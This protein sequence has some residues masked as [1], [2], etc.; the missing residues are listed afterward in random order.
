MSTEIDEWIDEWIGAEVER[1]FAGETPLRDPRE[2]AARG[3]RAQR[4]RRA[5]GSALGFAAVAVVAAL[6]VGGLHPGTGPDR[7]VK[8]AGG[9]AGPVRVTT[10]LPVDPATERECIRHPAIDCGPA[11]GWDDLH[12]DANG[13]LVRGYPDVEVTGRYDDVYSPSYRGSSALEVR[14]G[15]RV[16]WVLATWS[17]EEVIGVEFSCPDPTRTFDQWV[18]DSSASQL[19]GAWRDYTCAADVRGTGSTY[20]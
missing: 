5:A 11:I 17:D 8:P 18:A 4:R 12:S 19:G 13:E 14:R 3:R 2:Y 1:S 10:A 15:G 20:R 9:W 7:D 16:A 6:T